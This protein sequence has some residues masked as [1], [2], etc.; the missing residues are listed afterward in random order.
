LIEAQSMLKFERKDPKFDATA[1]RLWKIRPRKAGPLI[2]RNMIVRALR[3]AGLSHVLKG[4]SATIG[5]LYPPSFPVQWLIEASEALLRHATRRKQF[6]I[7]F[8]RGRRQRKLKDPNGVDLTNWLSESH[9]VFGFAAE[10][11]HFP[12]VFQLAAN[13]IVPLGSVDRR[14]IDV[15]FRA[16]LG[17]VPSEDVLE[18]TQ[19]LAP[20]L[21]GAVLRSGRTATGIAD[22]IRRHTSSSLQGSTPPSLD[23]YSG[24]GEAA[25]WGKA[26]AA[27]LANYAAGRL[28]WSE[29][30]RG[31][32]ISGPSGTGKTL[33][34]QV[35]AQTCGIPLFA[36]SL[37]RWQARGHLGDL[38]AAMNAAFDQAIDNA[39]CII[40]LDECDA[41]GSRDRLSGENE[42]YSREVI[43]GLLESLDGVGKREGVVVIGA[44]NMPEKLD[45]ALLRPGRLGRHLKILLPD[46]DD[47]NG[48]LRHHL[49]VDL[50]EEDL[51][52]PIACLD[53]ATG[54]VIEQVVR[55]AR[56]RARTECRQIAI[57]DIA[58]ALP[59]RIRLSDPAFVR[60]CIHEAGHALVGRRL[61]DISGNMVLETRVSREF[62]V[63]R[64][65]G[66][67]SF[68]RVPGFDRTRAAY[69]AEI[70]ALLSGLAAE[71]VILGQHADGGGGTPESDLYQATLLAAQLET[72]L[73]L[74]LTL[75]CTTSPE[76]DQLIKRLDHD[77]ALRR[78]VDT[79]LVE[80]M[81]G[82]KTMLEKDRRPLERIAYELAASIGFDR[83]HFSTIVEQ[84]AGS[85]GLLTHT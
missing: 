58:M 85:S 10:I 33:F 65:G 25:D 55:D 54:A 47:R 69:I 42:Q 79:I 26:L 60:A 39:P 11:A 13:R 36:H 75:A 7:E 40:F 44:T 70:T 15:A 67:T 19:Q 14:A 41:F 17:A 34:A 8:T 59:P 6:C 56:R 50:Q 61:E 51:S 18:T 1:R 9:V 74:G 66:Q 12:D 24:F 22:I 16:I 45:P 27:D 68:H 23:A 21:L 82:A 20:N 71:T 4:Q 38:L 76:P 78:T 35:L 81:N 72:S 28:P 46:A 32:L 63:G 29:I 2:A 48:I 84:I 37:A 77:P 83:N 5:F 31:A 30:D 49:G 57:T 52:D 43:N 3:S 62:L 80:C 73:G 64:S 53:G